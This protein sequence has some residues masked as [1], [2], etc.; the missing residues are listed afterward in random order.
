MFSLAAFALV[1]VLGVV[2][3]AY[4]HKWLAKV[5]GAPANITPATAQD[6]VD[7][8]VAHGKGAALAA[9][10]YT[11]EAAKAVHLKV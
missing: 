2:I 8:L 7:S 6:A 9:I 4:S 1:L 10:D 3:G 5:T 11:A